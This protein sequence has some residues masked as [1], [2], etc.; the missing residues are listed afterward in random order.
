MISAIRAAHPG[1]IEVGLI[2]LDDGT[3]VDA[4]QRIG[5]RTSMSGSRARSARHWFLDLNCA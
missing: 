5:V 3:Y 1:L 2:H 4:L